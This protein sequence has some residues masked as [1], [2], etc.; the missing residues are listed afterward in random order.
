MFLQK[1]IRRVFQQPLS[2]S[3]RLL[4]VSF[5]VALLCLVFIAAGGRQQLYKADA[6]VLHDSKPL[7]QNSLE[8]SV[9]VP[10]QVP[11]S[12]RSSPFN[13]NRNLTVPPNFAISVYARIANLKSKI[14]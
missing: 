11:V 10:V 6:S 2:N 12:M 4:G 9:S 8:A 5:L 3:T 1:Q 13:V 14:L 7:L